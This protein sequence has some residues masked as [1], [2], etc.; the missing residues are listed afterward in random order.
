MIVVQPRAQMVRDPMSHT[1]R[2]RSAKH[3]L[4]KGGH[5]SLCNRDETGRRGARVGVAI[6]SQNA[7]GYHWFCPECARA[8]SRVCP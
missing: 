7:V 4:G 1:I 8:I 2:A 5:C 6:R 3:R